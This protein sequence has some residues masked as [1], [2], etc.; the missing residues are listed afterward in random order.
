MKRFGMS[1]RHFNRLSRKRF[2]VSEPTEVGASSQVV[3]SQYHVEPIPNVD[4]DCDYDAINSSS[5][6]GLEFI[7]PLST[8]SESNNDVSSEEGDNSNDDVPKIQK[9]LAEWVAANHITEN[10][11]DKLLQTLIANK[12]K[13]IPKCAK[14]LMLTPRHKIKYNS[15]RNTKS[16]FEGCYT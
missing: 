10:A 15:F 5:D 16:F 13:D 14:T 1:K 2:D 8:E 7:D 11:T 12:V 4:I 9:D 6:D 3:Q